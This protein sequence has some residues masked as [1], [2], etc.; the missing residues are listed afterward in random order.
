[1]TTAPAPVADPGAILE[2]YEQQPQLHPYGIADVVQLWDR[3]TW[4][5]DGPAVVGVLDLPG[6]PVPVLY[7]VS[8]SPA[9]TLD[10][11]ARVEPA[12]PPDLM[13]T[14]PEGLAA[15]LSNSYAA[16]FVSPYVKMHLAR[17]RELPAPS[18]DAVTLSTDDLADV[19]R[20]FETDPLAGDFFHPALLDTGFYLGVRPGA[21]LATVGGIHV[22]AEDRGV[23]AI[24]NVTTH[25]AHRRRG[26]ARRVVATLSHQ[27]LEHVV[28]IGLNVRQDNAAALALY[29]ALG[30]DTIAPYEEARLHRTSGRNSGYA[31]PRWAQRRRQ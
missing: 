7:A 28:T 6:S 14:G 18:A 22:M 8:A 5:R 2:V 23:A 15:R 17:P 27:L 10:L 13:A 21:A 31:D 1:M 11:L 20:L 29:G 19:E 16:S 9:A 12:L 30:F 26:L 3:S 25:P 4:W 24:G